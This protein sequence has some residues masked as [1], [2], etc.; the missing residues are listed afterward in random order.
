MP[1]AMFG[2]V[3]GFIIEVI[4]A[5]CS[6]FSGSRFREFPN[7]HFFYIGAI[8]EV[9]IIIGIDHRDPGDRPAR[10][11][12]D[13]AL[14]VESVNPAG[15]RRGRDPAVVQAG[16]VLVRH[17]GCGLVRHLLVVL[18][19]CRIVVQASRLRWIWRGHALCPRR[20]RDACT[21]RH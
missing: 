19:G 6:R 9:I 21:T 16:Q 20:R 5:C 1:P 15:V 13:R 4:V 14:H 10:L 11:L 3:G 12:Q 17:H 8:A 18:V 7:L 2:L